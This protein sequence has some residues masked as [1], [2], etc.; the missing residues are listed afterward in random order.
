MISRKYN[1]KIKSTKF[2]TTITVFVVT[3][4]ILI[5]CL[6]LF[7]MPIIVR[8]GEYQ[9]KMILT[10]II[11]NAVNEVLENS[12]LSYQDVVT[13][14]RDKN[15]KITSI[16]SDIYTINKIK[17]KIIGSVSKSFSEMPL[18]RYSLPIG[19]LLGNQ[20]FIGRGPAI[21][22]TIIPMGYLDIQIES[23]FNAAG[24]NQ[25]NHKMMLNMTLNYTTAI[26]LHQSSAKLTDHFIMI[27][28]IIVGEV[29]QYYTNLSNDKETKLGDV[30]TIYP[31]SLQ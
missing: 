22:L 20:F 15:D 23:E 11:S 13:I 14:E 5:I 30:R 2:S 27:D 18:H 1:K 21:T 19:T 25:T 28:T 7:V 31:Q 10:G 4:I 29:P 26:P 9:G 12:D 16:E 8:A 17:T 24:I 3:T 6:E